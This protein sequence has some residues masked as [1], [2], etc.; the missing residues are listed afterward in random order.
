MSCFYSLKLNYIKKDVAARDAQA[1]RTP[2]TTYQQV[3]NK[4]RQNAASPRVFTTLAR[5]ILRSFRINYSL[6]TIK[7]PWQKKKI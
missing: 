6:F 1:M 3:G 2:K 5:Q 7:K 4:P